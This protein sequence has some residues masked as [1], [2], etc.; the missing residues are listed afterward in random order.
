ML[1]GNSRKLAWLVLGSDASDL[2]SAYHRR[3]STRRD[4]DARGGGGRL[5]AG[6]SAKRNAR[7]NRMRALTTF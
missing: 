1:L 3:D 4:S 5:Y 6:F 7:S 2:P